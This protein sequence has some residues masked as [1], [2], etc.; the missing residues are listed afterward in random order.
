MFD[1]AAAEARYYAYD[2]K[3]PGLAVCVTRADQLTSKSKFSN[4]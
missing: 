4:K 3:Q 2:V 1:S